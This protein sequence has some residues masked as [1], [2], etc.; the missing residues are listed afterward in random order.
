MPEIPRLSALE[1]RSPIMDELITDAQAEWLVAGVAAALLVAA[2]GWFLAARD[3]MR[4]ALGR[5]GTS[6]ALAAGPI[7]YLLWLLDGA[8]IHW[9]GFDTL[10]RV[11]VEAG[12]F[13]ALGLSAGLWLRGETRQP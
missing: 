1:Q 4:S 10:L 5:R 11:G 12:I 9:L 3:L 8:L 7:I 13:V 2:L 6:L